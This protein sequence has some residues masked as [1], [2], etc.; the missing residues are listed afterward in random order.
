MGNNIDKDPRINAKSMTVWQHLG[1]FLA[2]L[3]FCGSYA[4]LFFLQIKRDTTGT[5]IALSMFTYIVVISLMMSAFFAVLRKKYFMKP[6]YRLSEAARRVAHGDFTVRIA[7]MRKD[8][9]KDELEVLFDDFNTMAAELASTEI[10]K[11]DFIYNVS[12][13]FKTPLA[14]IQN[15]ATILQ[16][17]ALTEA[18]RMRYCQ[19]IGEVSKNLTVLITNILQ[20][21][22]LENQKIGIVKRTYN[23]SEQLSRCI[24][25]YDSALE[26]KNID[27]QIEMDQ[28]LLVSSDEQL[29]DI[30]WNN[31]L[32]NAVKFTPENGHIHIMVW[33]EEGTAMVEVEDSGC[34]MS[35]EEVKRIFEKFY[36]VDASHSGAGNG[37]GLALVKRI[38][39]IV[40]GEIQVQ[41]EPDVG[42]VFTVMLK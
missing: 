31:L 4:G 17:E 2:V 18:E 14:A 41:S 22:K 27:L 34:G 28:D 15:Y 11:N 39:E 13:E 38:L 1:I 26:E 42:T 23:L 36:Q 5:Y 35:A 29:M 37:L 19:R 24:L 30:V 6:I 25:N 32:S 16:H 21:N 3:F 40:D 33:C 7:P 10:L 8:G 20:L 9:K 12:H